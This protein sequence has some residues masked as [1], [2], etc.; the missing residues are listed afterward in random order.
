[1]T[2]NS[3]FMS[4]YLPPENSEQHR[5]HPAPAEDATEEVSL[6]DV[7]VPE[8]G[9]PQSPHIP[10][11]GGYEFGPPPAEGNRHEA[12]PGAPGALKVLTLR[13]NRHHRRRRLRGP[14]SGRRRRA[15]IPMLCRGP[16]RL[17][18]RTRSRQLGA[19][20]QGR[21][22]TRSRRARSSISA[23]RRRHRVGHPR[24]WTPS[25][26][27]RRGQ[28]FALPARHPPGMSRSRRS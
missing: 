25:N 13:P 18:H 10:P 21:R 1:M 23:T 20:R 28:I 9:A 8:P 6:A 7:R 19:A 26:G 27:G 16:R 11:V 5:E 24:V 17:G 14:R 3:D 12:W 2:D 15:G 22:P 4:R